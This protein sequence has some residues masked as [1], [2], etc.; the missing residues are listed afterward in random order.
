MNATMHMDAKINKGTIRQEARRHG[1]NTT[2]A[3]GA[4]TRVG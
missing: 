1:D 3:R 2:Q 4:K